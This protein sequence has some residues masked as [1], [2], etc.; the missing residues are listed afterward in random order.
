LVIESP[1]GVVVTRRITSSDIEGHVQTTCDFVENFA[2]ELG[3][4]RCWLLR[5]LKS[6]LI[7]NGFGYQKREIR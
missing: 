4:G 6:T 7:Y 5:V 2:F 3:V 1:G